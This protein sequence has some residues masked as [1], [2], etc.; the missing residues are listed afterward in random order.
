MKFSLRTKVILFGLLI[1]LGLIFRVPTTPHELGW[2]SFSVH[3]M[4][5]SISEFGYAKWWLHLT[6]ITGSYPYSTS[7]SAVPFVLSGISQCT[8]MDTEKVILLYSIFL[9]LFA[10]FGAYLMAGAIWDNDIFTFLVAIVFSTSQG[11]VT[12]STWTA[13][14]RTLFVILLP[15]FIYLLLKTHTFKV[16]CGILTFIILALL[17][18]T[19]HYIYFTI[20]VLL[21]FFII[22]IFYKFGEHIKTI[23][24]PE[25]FAN[26]AMLGCF[27]IM[28]SIGYFDRSLWWND[29]EMFRSV[30]EGSGSI[31]VWISD[32]MLMQYVR[33]I[34]FSIIFVVSGYIF[35]T[36]KRD[37]RFEEW[38]F[39]LCL[40]GLAPLLYIATYTKWFIVPFACILIGIAL[41]NIAIVK[42][43]TLKRKLVPS[44]VVITILLLSISFTGYY[45]YL[46]FLNDPSPRTR[47]MEERTYVG[48]L[49]LKDNI[50]KNKN[51]IAGGLIGH[52]ICSISEVPIL[53]GVGAADLAYGF[54]E[55]GKIEVKQ[56]YSSTSLGYYRHDPYKVVNHS[57][58]DWYVAHILDGDINDKRDVAYR[59]ISKFNLSFYAVNKDIRDRLSQSVQK[60]KDLYYDNG[61]IGIWK[62]D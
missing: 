56:I 16:R 9:G 7:P 20:P 62:L 45:Q 1:L 49:W 19:H 59:S 30:S 60:T 43:H 22:A 47:Y 23:K 11:M 26:F 53:T 14:A 29:P 40:A 24:I 52:R 25:N 17:L 34:G 35:L 18:V 57:Y 15:L 33:Y 37:K 27:L 12:F 39:L 61:K 8:S 4:A 46:H 2:D 58:T 54:V 51:M 55:P 41:T 5:N 6:S 13:H 50:D 44:L 10:I 3:L 21:S 36:F 42:T 31:Y 28:F 48:G 38:L 32:I